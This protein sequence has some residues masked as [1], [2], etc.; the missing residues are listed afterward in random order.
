MTGRRGGFALPVSVIVLV[1]VGLALGGMLFF[2]GSQTQ[3]LKGELRAWRARRNALSGLALASE[4]L[5]NERWY[6]ASTLVGSLTSDDAGWTAEDGTF[7]LVAEDIRAFVDNPGILDGVD[8]GRLAVLD[9]VDLFSVGEFEGVQRVAYGRFI[10]S[11]SPDFRGTSTDGLARLPNSEVLEVTP[12]TIK[13]LARVTEI[14][15]PKL[16]DVTVEAVR[17]EI[18]S[19]IAAQSADFAANYGRVVR[20]ASVPSSTGTSLDDS[21]AAALLALFWSDAAPGSG[22]GPLFLH[23]RM[24]DA[25]LEGTAPDQRAGAREQRQVELELDPPSDKRTFIEACC[26]LVGVEVVD[27]QPVKVFEPPAA[28]ADL[29]RDRGQEPPTA[30]YREAVGANPQAM[31]KYSVS[32]GA[33]F[34]GGPDGFDEA[35]VQQASTDPQWNNGGIE[36]YMLWDGIYYI[37]IKVDGPTWITKPYR[38]E[39]PASSRRLLVDDMVGFYEKFYGEAGAA[40]VGG[41]VKNDFN[42]GNIVNPPPGPTTSGGGCSGGW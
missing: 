24:L 5:R 15:D 28:V 31:V 9:R 2:S 6:G 8:W 1:I 13:R 29:N 23:D 33:T 19:R 12:S 32:W 36:N 7:F 42:L 30:D 17:N 14:L 21:A 22:G 35:A 10:M 39:D 4:R 11:P 18:R 3:S 38:I 26:R 25:V 41:S 34:N 20:S 37:G 40:P 27:P 16:V